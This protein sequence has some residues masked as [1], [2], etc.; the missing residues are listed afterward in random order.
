MQSAQ[1]GVCEVAFMCSLVVGRWS[2]VVVCCLCVLSVS[3]SKRDMERVPR[4][5][6]FNK[7]NDGFSPQTKWS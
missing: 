3:G 6:Y 1:R 4:D 7:N 2:L 5:S